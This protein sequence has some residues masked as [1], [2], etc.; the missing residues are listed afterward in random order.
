[1]QSA[2]DDE[3]P[4]IFD[5][6]NRC[7]RET[8]TVK[9]TSASKEAAEVIFSVHAEYMGPFVDNQ[10]RY[11]DFQPCSFSKG[12]KTMKSSRYWEPP[13]DARSLI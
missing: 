7:P 11:E 10:N 6:A 12:F 2:F 3:Q 5:N 9:A 13:F 8:P 1:M 4:P